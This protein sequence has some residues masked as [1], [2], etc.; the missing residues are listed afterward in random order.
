MVKMHFP[1]EHEL[2]VHVISVW[3]L[4]GECVDCPIEIVGL[5]DLRNP[6]LSAPQHCESG[7]LG[8]HMAAEIS[9]DQC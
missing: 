6:T 9:P 3:R 4:G 8:P 5:Y 7:D 1:I 2:E